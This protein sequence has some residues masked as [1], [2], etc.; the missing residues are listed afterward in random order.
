MGMCMCICLHVCIYSYRPIETPRSQS[1]TAPGLDR[2]WEYVYKNMLYM[3]IYIYTYN[4][5][6]C[7]AIDGSRRRSRRVWHRLDRKQRAVGWEEMQPYTHIYAY[8]LV[9]PFYINRLWMYIYANTYSYIRI[10]TPRSQSLTAPELHRE[11]MDFTEDGNA[12]ICRYLCICIYVYMCVCIHIPVCIYSYWRIE[13]PRSHSLTAPGLRRGW[14]HIYI[15]VCARVPFA[16]Q[17]SVN[18][19]ICKYM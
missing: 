1:L 7:I 12:D 4:L 15:C 13:T 14:L 8:V 18:V 10:E 6:V 11:W 17:P 3:Y 2:G 5:Q 16:Y 9:S 19:C